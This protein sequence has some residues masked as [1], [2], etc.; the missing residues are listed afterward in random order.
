MYCYYIY[1]FIYLYVFDIFFFK[2][3]MRCTQNCSSLN[4]IFTQIS[5]VWQDGSL[6]HLLDWSWVVEVPEELHMWA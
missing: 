1:L 6:V 4:Q 3:R 2:H 5:H